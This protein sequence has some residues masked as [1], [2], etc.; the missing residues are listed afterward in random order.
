MMNISKL[1]LGGSL[2]GLVLSGGL[3]ACGDKEGDDTGGPPGPQDGGADGGTGDGGTDGG[4]GDGGGDGGGGDGG[5]DGGDGGGDGGGTGPDPRDGSYRGS[6]S[7][8]LIGPSGDLADTCVGTTVLRVQVDG[9]RPIEGT[10]NC[11]FEGG[12]AGA[13]PDAYP[14]TIEGTVL[15]ATGAV[16]SLDLN[17]A[18]TVVAEDWTG[19]F[20]KDGL[21]SSFNGSLTLGG[22]NYD[23][24][25]G[26]IVLLEPEKPE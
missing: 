17:L 19:S 12:L 1:L 3:L 21:A 11:H 10:A 15:D 5:G 20:E 4:T 6:F 16:G 13:Y 14:A 7:M 25:G 22:T 8:R 24:T 26:F 9:P 2:M 23:Y 18:G